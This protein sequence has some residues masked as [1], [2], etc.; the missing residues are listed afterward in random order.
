MK[1]ITAKVY[2]RIEFV[3]DSPLMIGSKQQERTDKD[4]LV[5]ACGRPIIPGSALAGIYRSRLSLD[6]EEE[7][8]YFGDVPDYEAWKKS[9][10][11]KNYKKPDGRKT[12]SVENISSRI[13][14]YDAVLKSGEKP[15][16]TRRD[17]V[18]LDEFKTAEQ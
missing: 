2:Y 9:R 5:D 8:I 18:A 1:K 10:E 16:I 14:V 15:Y 13:I 3:L 4:L 11:Q 7:K 6:K 17:F 12:D